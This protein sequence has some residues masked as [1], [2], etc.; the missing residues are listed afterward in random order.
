MIFGEST[1]SYDII[2][3]ELANATVKPLLAT[4]RDELMPSWA[5][6][7]PLLA[8]LTDR[9]GPQEIW[10]HSDDN[11]D[12]PLVTA[13]DFR[14]HRAMVHG[15]GDGAQGDRVVS[16]KESGRWRCA[17]ACGSRRWPVDLPCN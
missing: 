2:S 3:V 14:D 7:K 8:Y 6:G 9:N 11:S 10:L 13:R 17:S 4:E 5:A 12:R 15:A 1:G 16:A